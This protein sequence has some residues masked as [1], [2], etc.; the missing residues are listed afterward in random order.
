MTVN[1]QH[2]FIRHAAKQVPLT[3]ILRTSSAASHRCSL[4][5]LW[6]GSPGH[7]LQF[8]TKLFVDAFGVQNPF[9]PA[10][11]PSVLKASRGTPAPTAPSSVHMPAKRARGDDAAARET[12]G[13]FTAAAARARQPDHQAYDQA[14]HEAGLAG[15]GAQVGLPIPLYISGPCPS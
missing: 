13:E 1:L 5:Q 7:A 9:R 6:S 4:A 11:D 3:L 8:L 12:A 2:A 14:E 15:Q 10:S